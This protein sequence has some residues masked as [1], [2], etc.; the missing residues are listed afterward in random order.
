MKKVYQLIVRGPMKYFSGG[1]HISSKRLF[2][3]RQRALDYLPT[4]TLLCTQDPDGAASLAT[5]ETVVSHSVAELEL[6]EEV[7]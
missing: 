7:G 3:S 6:D 2:T 4:F 5:L 1:H